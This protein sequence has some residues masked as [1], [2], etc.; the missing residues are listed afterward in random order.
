M[1]GVRSASEVFMHLAAT[2]YML[3]S[4]IGT[5]IPE[6]AGFTRGTMGD[7]ERIADKEDV[8][9]ALRGSFEHMQQVI[10][11]TPDSE[12]DRE[13]TIFGQPGTV[14]S[15]FIRACNHAHE[16]LG[17]MIAYARSNQVVPPWSG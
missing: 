11:S 3:P 15:L 2:N 12:L 9:T 14:R 4:L 17:Q 7:Y 6:E 13:V 16:H 1:E 8:V 10:A 5:P